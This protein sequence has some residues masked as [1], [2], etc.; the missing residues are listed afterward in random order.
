MAKH[1]G[2]DV[3]FKQDAVVIQKYKKYS[4]KEFAKLKS[5]KGG[6]GNKERPDGLKTRKGSPGKS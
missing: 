4:K 2:E 5:W 1:Y 6:L 3:C